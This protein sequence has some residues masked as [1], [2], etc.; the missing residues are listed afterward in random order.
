[1][2]S[3]VVAQVSL[4]SMCSKGSHIFPHVHMIFQIVP[5]RAL[6]YLHIKVGIV[7]FCLLHATVVA[8]S[9]DIFGGLLASHLAQEIS[10]NYQF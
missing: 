3:L 5:Q 10:Q 6:I 7:C 4:A 2:G 9:L 1:M 8:W